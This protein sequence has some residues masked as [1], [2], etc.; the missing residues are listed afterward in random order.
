M[1]NQLSLFAASQMF[2]KFKLLMFT[3]TINKSFQSLTPIHTALL[4]L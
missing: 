1:S 2:V 4:F 3:Q